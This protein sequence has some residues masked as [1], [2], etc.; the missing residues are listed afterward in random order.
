[1]TKTKRT[2][3][4]IDKP[5]QLGFILRF[6]VVILITIACC[7]SVIALYYYQDSLLGT[8]RL[9]QNVTIKTRG[10]VST[11]EGY[12]IYLYDKEKIEVF[13]KVENGKKSYYCENPFSNTNFSK[14]SQVEN[15]N[16]SLLEPKMGPIP[17]ETKMFFIVIG[18]LIWM[19]IA[20]CIVISIYSIFFS[21]KMAGP[22]YR[23]RISLDRMLA[24][25]LDFK[26]NVRKNDFFTNIVEKLEQL[27][28]KIKN[29]E[30][31]SS[32]KE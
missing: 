12:K 15:V 28:N 11:A 16:E 21:H 8:N 5:F 25:D 22:V 27:R 10:H 13:L 19:T 31:S 7:F 30:Y 4:L 18:P 23:L 20:I 17:K 9:D 24:G 29:S 32:S 14:G 26:I 3:Y 6:L 2:N 1:V